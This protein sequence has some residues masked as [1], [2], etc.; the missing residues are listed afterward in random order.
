MRRKW[1]ETYL[2]I[3]DS[4]IRRYLVCCIL[5]LL[6]KKFLAEIMRE[7]DMLHFVFYVGS[8]YVRILESLN[9]EEGIKGVKREINVSG[10]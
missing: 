8:T 10:F 2:E 9:L 4:F 7:N 1:N 5:P 3:N 6:L